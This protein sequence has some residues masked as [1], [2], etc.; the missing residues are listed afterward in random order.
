[1]PI[2]YAPRAVPQMPSARLIRSKMYLFWRERLV[3]NASP[4]CAKGGV[5][6]V[7]MLSVTQDGKC[8]SGCIAESIIATFDASQR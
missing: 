3:M 4:R 5:S 7:F 6:P 8:N 1:M 2:K